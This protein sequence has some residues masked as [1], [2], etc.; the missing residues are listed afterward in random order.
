MSTWWWCRNF[1]TAW[2]VFIS[3]LCERQ[4]YEI[5]LMVKLTVRSDLLS[6]DIGSLREFPQTVSSMYLLCV[7]VFQTVLTDIRNMEWVNFFSLEQ[8]LKKGTILQFNRCFYF[9]PNRHFT[10]SGHISDLS[11]HLLSL[12]RTVHQKLSKLLMKHEIYPSIYF[13]FLYSSEVSNSHQE[14]THTVNAIIASAGCLG[15][16]FSWHHFWT[17]SSRQQRGSITVASCWSV[18]CRAWWR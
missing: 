11:F 8:S 1:W 9:Y 4:K 13:N 10:P 12:E 7:C 14:A 2:S 15:L 17:C 6:D 18:S 5:C 16:P 3:L